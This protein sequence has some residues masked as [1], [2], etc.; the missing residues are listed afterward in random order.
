MMEQWDE[1]SEK[2]SK[3]R[4]DFEKAKGLLKLTELREHKL[5]SFQ[6]PAETT[7]LAEAYYEIVKEI[8]TA[9][10]SIDGWKTLSHELLISYLATFYSEFSTSEVMLIDQLRQM[11]NDIAYRGIMIKPEYIEGNKKEIIVIINKLK[12]RL[13]EK[14]SKTT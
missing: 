12:N 3:L 1:H 13:F 2:V 14:L 4:P 6:L 8:I 10:M 5:T 11:R 9:I 7:L